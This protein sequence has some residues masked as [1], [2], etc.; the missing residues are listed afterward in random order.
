MLLVM[1][2]LL[3][4]ALGRS[5]FQMIFSLFGYFIE[6]IIGCISII[7]Y[8][9]LVKPCFQMSLIRRR[10]RFIYRLK[11]FFR[12]FPLVALPRLITLFIGFRQFTISPII[13]VFM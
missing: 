1:G 2:C 6:F 3:R 9:F 4:S 11:P 8:A 5:L 7:C 10:I 12:L 13:C